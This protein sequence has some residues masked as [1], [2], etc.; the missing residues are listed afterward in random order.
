[1]PLRAALDGNKK[2]QANLVRA[3][4]LG[5]APDILVSR[6]QELT[7]E[8]AELEQKIRQAEYERP[9]IPRDVIEGWLRSFKNGDKK[10][11]EFRKRLIETFVARVDVYNDKAV[12]YY[13][14]TEKKA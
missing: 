11:P 7:D 2:K 14:I 4:E 10:D 3:I 5:N 1:M 9:T 6:L 12:I 8:A 13:N